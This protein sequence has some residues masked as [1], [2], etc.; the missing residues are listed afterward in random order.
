MGPDPGV[1][2]GTLEL[3]PVDELASWSRRD[4]L[5]FLELFWLGRLGSWSCSQWMHLKYG[6]CSGW[7]GMG[8]AVPD[9]FRVDVSGSW[10]CSGWMR[11]GTGV[12]R[13]GWVVGPGI[14]V[15]LGWMRWVLG[16]ASDGV[17]GFR[18]LELFQV[19]EFGSWNSFGSTL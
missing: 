17:D 8:P 13:G 3:P 18:V 14:K 16:E 15:D 9:L 19:N 2:R 7:T 5:V 6:S 10:S 1:V 11:L 12:V 4:E